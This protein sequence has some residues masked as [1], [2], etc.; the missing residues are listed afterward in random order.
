[1]MRK[2]T[3]ESIVKSVFSLFY[4]R[5]S[6]KKMYHETEYIRYLMIENKDGSSTINNINP[7]FMRYINDLKKS[8][9]KHDINLSNW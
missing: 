2:I 5:N 1:M 3:K 9:S 7:M 4:G 6:S 8:T